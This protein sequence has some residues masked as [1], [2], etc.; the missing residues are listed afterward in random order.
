MFVKPL[1]VVLSC[2]IRTSPDATSPDATSPDLDQ[3]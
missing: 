2:E 1:R 3:T